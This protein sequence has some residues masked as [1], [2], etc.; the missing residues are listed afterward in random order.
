MFCACSSPFVAKPLI[1]FGLAGHYQRPVF[2]STEILGTVFVSHPSYDLYEKVILR[3]FR[4][5]SI[6]YR[7]HVASDDRALVSQRRAPRGRAGKLF[8]KTADQKEAS[9]GTFE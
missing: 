3:C 5:R 1:H 4:Q 9:H 6:K 7:W 2:V 8:E